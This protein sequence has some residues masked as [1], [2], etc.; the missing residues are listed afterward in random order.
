[1]TNGSGRRPGGRTVTDHCRRLW[2]APEADSP[3]LSRA[4]VADACH[5]WGLPGL[6]HPARLVMSELA[7]NAVEHAGT[8]FV[9]TVNRCRSGLHLSVADGDRRLPR[10]RPPRPARAGAPL[11]ERGRGIRTVD[12]TAWV[13]GVLPTATG[14]VVWA[15]LR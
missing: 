8:D 15:V 3:S 13:W 5:A 12:A 6:L 11:D 2:L 9:V 14:K 10:W 4:L 1:M 7:L